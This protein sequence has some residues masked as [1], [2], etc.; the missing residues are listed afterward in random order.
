[1]SV[2]LRELK[3]NRLRQAVEREAL[4]LFVERGYE[5]TTVEQIAEAAEISTTTFYRYYSGKE[6]VLVVGESGPQPMRDVLARRPEGESLLEA[7]RATMREALEPVRTTGRQAALQRLALVHRIPEIRARMERERTDQLPAFAAMLGERMG[8]GPQS[9]RS[10]LAAAVISAGL[11]EAVRYWVD[12]D[13][14]P[15]LLDLIDE[16]LDD[17]APLLRASPPA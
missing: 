8:T 10:R 13:G 14:R 12:H 1:M 16:L 2:S 4:R 11:G 3:K 17:V 15:E 6:E 9:Y 7:L 5:E